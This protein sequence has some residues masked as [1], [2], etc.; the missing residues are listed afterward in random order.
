[1]IEEQRYLGNV[2]QNWAQCK[3]GRVIVTDLEGVSTHFPA[4]T[5]AIIIMVNL[6]SKRQ[7]VMQRLV[8]EIWDAHFDNV[9]TF[10]F[11]K[12][13]IAGNKMRRTRRQVERFSFP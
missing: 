1:M 3:A 2:F 12:V 9:V 8:A 4:V 13:E 6:R 7:T 11:W 10:E 5:L